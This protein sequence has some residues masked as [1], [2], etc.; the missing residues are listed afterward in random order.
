MRIVVAVDHIDGTLN[1]N[2]M[3]AGCAML[4]DE[5]DSTLIEVLVGQL[6][7]PWQKKLSN[8]GKEAAPTSNP[9]AQI[10]ESWEA[11]CWVYPASRVCSGCVEDL[12][13]SLG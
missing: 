11:Q 5:A 1:K 10:Y 6:L 13:F 7:E 4:E 12:V 8:V 2:K 3:L 9:A